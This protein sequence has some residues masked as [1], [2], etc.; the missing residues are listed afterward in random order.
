VKRIVALHEITDPAWRWVSRHMPEYEWQFVF[1]PPATGSVGNRVK[2]QMAGLRAARLGRS[3]DLV[4]SFGAGL[5]SVLEFGRRA[6]GVKM[7]HCCYFL[8]YDRLPQGFTRARQRRAYRNVDRFVVSS[9]VERLLYTDHFD[10]DPKKFDVILWGVNPPEVSE[11]RMIEGDYVCAVGGNARDYSML[12]QVA[13]I[14]PEVPFVV[15][16]RPVNLQGLDIPANVRTLT[17]IPFADAMAIIRDA[18]AMALPLK[19]TETPCGHVT[20]VGAFYLGTPVAVTASA[21]IEDYVTDGATGLV[22]PTGS[23][24]AMGAAI[25]RLWSDRALATK[26][27]ESGRNF[28]NLHCTE[29]NYPAHVRKLLGD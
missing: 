12:M 21:G 4:I 29:A 24:E 15:V 17:N 3:A 25:D 13:R 8:N 27:G 19:T 16:A 14:R 20:I 22:T 11:G 7:P 18:R 2:R 10:L 5:A 23:A 26:L 28:A 6:L 1:A 9:G